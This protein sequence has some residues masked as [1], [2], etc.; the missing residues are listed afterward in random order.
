MIIGIDGNEA[1]VAE[2]VGVSWYVFNILHELRQQTE[3]KVVVFLRE[4][5][6]DDMPKENESFSYEVVPGKFLWS[7]IFL[8]IN[9][10]LKHRNLSVFLSPAHYAPRWCPVPTVVVIHDLSFFYYPE[11]FLKK[12]LY[13]LRAWT[14]YS[15]KQAAHVITVSETTRKDVLLHYR[16]PENKVTTV[17][18]GF[19]AATVKSS[20][21]SLP[22]ADTFLLYVTTIQPRKN[23]M[24]LLIAFEALLIN[25]PTLHLYIVG[26][27]GW[28]YEE[29]F[30]Y[31]QRHH[32]EKSVTCTGYLS[33]S[34]KLWMNEHAKLVVL[35]G[36]YEGFGL[37]ML[38]AFS[39]GVPVAASNTGALPEVGSDACTYFEP[40]DAVNISQIIHKTLSDEKVRSNLVT[41]GKKRL[42][43]F[44]WEKTTSGILLVLKKFTHE[45]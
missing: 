33:E 27:K 18:N 31:V 1:N 45:T 16:I 19:T 10:F 37:P 12:D 2:R 22:I 44:D 5:P 26:K 11:S 15:V 24:R 21:P 36:L 17:H 43:T 25:H 29:I 38:E 30:D 28:L 13:Q 41:A 9:L 42:K 4:S 39:A 3:Q 7:Q 35:P 40:L 6:R 14:Q 8:P 23:I 20:K 34:E 32:L